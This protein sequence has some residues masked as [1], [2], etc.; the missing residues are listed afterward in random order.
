MKI[1]QNINTFISSSRSSVVTTGTFDGVHIGHQQ[2][3]KVLKERALH[4]GLESILVTF[5]P[6]PRK[7]VQKDASSLQILSTLDEKIDLFRSIGVDHLII[8]PFTIDFS[9]ISFTLYLRDYLKEKLSMNHMVIGHDHH[10]GKNR[11]GSY[12][13]IKELEHTYQFTVE[14]VP[15]TQLDGIDISSTKIRQE[16]LNSNVSKANQWLG[17]KYSFTGKVISGDKI[18]RTMGYPTANIKPLDP[19]KLV[20]GNGV[21]AVYIEWN[22]KIFKAMAHIGPRPTFGKSELTIEAHLFDFTETIYDE[23]VK[24][25]FVEKLRGVETFETMDELMIALK[26][27]QLNA[28]ALL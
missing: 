24:I 18:G 26:K 22:R 2:V 25:I 10:F 23:T 6:H 3:L 12:E 27:D 15:A 17:R 13:N 5:D 7:I 28:Q 4:L 20:P 14:Q 1:H 19:D 9:K 8:Q 21:Y 11:Q 16:L